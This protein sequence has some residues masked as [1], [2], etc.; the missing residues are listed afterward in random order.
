MNS[1]GASPFMLVPA[2]GPAGQLRPSLTISVLSLSLSLRS[3]PR[4]WIA[5]CPA[6]V[7]VLSLK[8][9]CLVSQQQRRCLLS[10]GKALPADAQRCAIALLPRALRP[11][12]CST[13]D[14]NTHTHARAHARAHTHARAHAQ[15]VARCRHSRE[16]HCGKSAHHARCSFLLSSPHSRAN[17]GSSSAYT[18]SPPRLITTLSSAPARD[19]DGEELSDSWVS[20]VPW[21]VPRATAWLAAHT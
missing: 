3:K 21:G 14:A 17:A 13:A 20:R 15:I 4:L 10:R 18:L 1:G 19:G 2:V 11:S 5:V 8:I 16:T 9:C 6:S 12:Q 7:A